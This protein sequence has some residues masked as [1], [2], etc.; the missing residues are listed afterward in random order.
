[1]HGYVVNERRCSFEKK[2]NDQMLKGLLILKYDDKKARDLRTLKVLVGKD[3]IN[4]EMFYY[5]ATDFYEYLEPG[6]SLI[7]DKGSLQ[8]KLI[9]DGKRKVHHLYYACEKENQ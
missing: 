5:E 3:T 9:R 8:I 7:K 1:M 6:D 4:S 2:V